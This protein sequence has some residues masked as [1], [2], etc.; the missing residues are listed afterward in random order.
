M[1]LK[2]I[3]RATREEDFE[4]VAKI[5]EAAKLKDTYFNQQTF[6]K[7]LERNRGYCFVAEYERKIVGTAFATHDGA[8]RG[9]IQKV[10]T[11]R[12]LRRQKIASKLVRRILEEFEKLN[13]PLVFAHVEKNNNPSLELLK[14]L[15]FEIRDSHYLLD[16]GY[17]SRK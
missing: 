3:V 6:K 15:G 2:I 17:K 5:L 1:N 16:K 8:F 10:A 14:S 12:T 13:I 11:D 4:A 7:M 9:Y